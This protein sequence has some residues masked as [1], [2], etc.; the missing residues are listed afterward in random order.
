MF[1]RIDRLK[2]PPQTAVPM[3]G[4]TVGEVATHAPVQ[5]TVHATRL[6]GAETPVE[7]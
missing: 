5:I 6:K 2:I 3:R 1:M 4:I 7:V